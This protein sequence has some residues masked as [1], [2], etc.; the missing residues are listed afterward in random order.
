MNMNINIWTY[1]GC[2]DVRDA[3]AHDEQSGSDGQNI[4]N[5]QTEQNGSDWR[6]KW[7]WP[8]IEVEYPNVGWEIERN[9]S[10]QQLN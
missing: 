4:L 7:L 8:T 5:Q 6:T 1:I 2:V 10:D 9:G 3:Q